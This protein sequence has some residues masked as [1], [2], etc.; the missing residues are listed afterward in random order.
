MFTIPK[1][2]FNNHSFFIAGD[3]TFS[4]I[5]L[6]GA[7]T[8]AHLVADC[9]AP[10]GQVQSQTFSVYDLEIRFTLEPPAKIRELS[11]FDV[12][13]GFYD[14]VTDAALT[15]APLPSGVSCSLALSDGATIDSG[16]TSGSMSDTTGILEFTGLSLED[17]HLNVQIVATCDSPYGQVQSQTFS[18]HDLEVRFSTEPPVATRKGGTFSVTL[19]F[20]DPV[21][22]AVAVAP[23]PS[24]VTCE[25][26]SKPMDD[27][28]ETSIDSGSMDCKLNNFLRDF[29]F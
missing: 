22:S 13:L 2:E 23:L 27:P 6:N 17:E 11:T 3:L 19:S 8:D 16:V 26:K 21:T 29:Y 10:Y 25:L 1:I 24:G 9:D 7:M 28:T 12:T 15:S 5:T 18:V 4:A 14:P 20:W